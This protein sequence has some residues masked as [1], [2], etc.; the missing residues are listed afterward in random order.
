MASGPFFRNT[1][2]QQVL[3]ASYPGTALGM[4]KSYSGSSCPWGG[5]TEREQTLL[6]TS[7]DTVSLLSYPEH[8]MED[9]SGSVA[10]HAGA[11]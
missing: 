10:E 3:E 9:E 8:I 5:H 7:G 1:K 2:K 6:G 11:Q 4:T